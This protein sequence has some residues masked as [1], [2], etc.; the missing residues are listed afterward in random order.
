MKST[1]RSHADLDL[2]ERLKHSGFVFTADKVGPDAIRYEATFEDPKVYTRPFKMAMTFG[3]LVRGDAARSY[4]L[5]EEAC[6]EGERNTQ[7][8]FFKLDNAR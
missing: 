2:F 8:M 7:D 4:E 5:M 3:R 6:L 1:C